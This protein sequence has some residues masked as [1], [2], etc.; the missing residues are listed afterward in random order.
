MDY[1]IGCDVGGTNTRLQLFAVTNELEA[2]IHAAAPG[3]LIDSQKYMNQDYESFQSILVEFLGKNKYINKKPNV[4]CLAVAGPINGRKAELTNRNW[5]IDCDFLAHEIGSHFVLINDFVAM[6]YGLLT[7]DENKECKILQKGNRVKGAPLACIGAGT[8]LG[9][10]YLT[11]SSSGEYTC[12]ASEGGHGEFAPRDD[13]EIK[14][15]KYLQNKFSN[16]YRASVERVV[17]GPGILNIYEFLVQENPLD[18]NQDVAKQLESARD[19][20]PAVIAQNIENCKNCKRSFDIFLSHYG[21]EAGVAALKWIPRG[22]LY[23][24]GGITQKNV[25][26]IINPN[27]DFMKSF[28]DKGRLSGV[29]KYV[30]LY[31]V[32]V[33]DLGERGAHWQAFAE[34]KRLLSNSNNISNNNNKVIVRTEKK[35]D[36]FTIL[37]N[38]AIG[39]GICVIVGNIYSRI[40]RNNN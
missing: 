26:T 29:V 40:L 10:C 25:D 28:I 21:C 37:T 32:L 6:G 33:E 13:L 31:A 9:E 16:K 39:L 27:G 7:L 36:D 17:S 2:I 1:I 20:K 19:L 14:L 15:L 4:I 5:I 35:K 34:Y 24:T 8:G 11:A 30:P 22:G 12:Y 23:L 18:T 3:T 38:V